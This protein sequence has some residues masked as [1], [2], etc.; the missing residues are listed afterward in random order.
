MTNNNNKTKKPAK[1]H[2]LIHERISQIM[3]EM[4]PIAKDAENTSQHYQY[5]SIDAV[6]SVVHELLTKHNV[7]YSPKVVGKD[8]Q[9]LDRIKNGEVVGK[10]VIVAFDVEYTVYCSE[11][12]SEITVGPIVGEAMDAGDKASAKAMTMALKTMLLQLFCIPVLNA[13]DPDGNGAAATTQTKSKA[14]ALLGEK[15]S[16]NDIQ[17]K[18]K[19]QA[20][21]YEL[22]GVNFEAD[23]LRSLCEEVMTNAKVKDIGKAADWLK[24]NATIEIGDL[25]EPI[26]EMLK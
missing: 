19:F 16:T 9:I 8:R 24:E 4:P 18:K 21:C 7:F 26:I 12:R 11:D 3:A 5:R 22:S 10:T 20:V 17:A 2:P 1:K 6:C 14:K 15:N 23:V 13:F 25:G